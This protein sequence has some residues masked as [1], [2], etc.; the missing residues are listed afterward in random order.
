MSHDKDGRAELR[1]QI[2]DELQNILACVRVQIPRRFV[3][4]Q[5]RRVNRQRSRDRN[6]LSLTSRKFVGKVIHAMA[7]LDKLQQFLCTVF[8]F[9]AGPFAQMKREGDIFQ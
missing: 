5:Y 6:T 7:E 8:D 2:A 9:L 3:R 1:M 4:K